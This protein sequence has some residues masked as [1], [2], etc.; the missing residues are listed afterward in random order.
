MDKLNSRDKKMDAEKLAVS[1]KAIENTNYSK[2]WISLVVFI[3]VSW[4]PFFGYMFH[5]SYL[6]DLGF[7]SV[8]VQLSVQESLWFFYS[9]MSW[10]IGKINDIQFKWFEFS[11]FI[12][13]VVCVITFIDLML[14]DSSREK[15]SVKIYSLLQKLSY[16]NAKGNLT[17]SFFLSLI[18]WVFLSVVIFLLPKIILTVFVIVFLFSVV[19]DFFGS[20][21]AKD[22]LEQKVCIYAP[23]DSDCPKIEID[24][25]KKSGLVVYSNEKSTFFVTLDGRYQLNDK[26]R[27]VQFRPFK[28]SQI[29]GLGRKLF[30]PEK[31]K[32]S[33]NDRSAMLNDFIANNK[34]N[35]SAERVFKV[36]GNSD[37]E[38]E[39]HY[40]EFPAY[41]LSATST[42]SVGF[43]FN[44]ETNEVV[45]VVKF[46]QC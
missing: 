46:G 1:E 7:Q 28:V 13:G 45:N 18:I 16:E 10:A 24:G 21:A 40:K 6:A 4:P 5:Q 44:W 33:I 38:K 27:V 42:C 19:G 29:H 39:F 25:N 43:P 41:K 12:G 20:E 23:F 14:K 35:L 2:Y 26:G 9:G 34:D 8:Y 11:I 36:L 17:K 22:E 3:V 30:T 31:W 15:V 37:S 32:T